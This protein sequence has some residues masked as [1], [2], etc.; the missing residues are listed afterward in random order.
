MHDKKTYVVLHVTS[1][2]NH[3]LVSIVQTYVHIHIHTCDFKGKRLVIVIQECNAI[4]FPD[5]PFK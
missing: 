4:V 1:T 3:P 2:S 5:N